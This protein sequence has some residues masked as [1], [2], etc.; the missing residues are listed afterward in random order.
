[1]TCRGMECAWNRTYELVGYSVLC[2]AL[3]GVGGCGDLD[4]MVGRLGKEGAGIVGACG[5]GLPCCQEGR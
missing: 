3:Q 1:M 5:R 2:W 4:A